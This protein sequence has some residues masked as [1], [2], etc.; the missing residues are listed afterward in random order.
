M[1]T[2]FTIFIPGII[3]HT[4]MFTIHPNFVIKY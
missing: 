3:F 1:T 4:T 2:F